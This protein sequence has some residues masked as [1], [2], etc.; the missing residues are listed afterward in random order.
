[1]SIRKFFALACAAGISLG[2][3]AELPVP[4]QDP[5]HPGSLQYSYEFEE[6]VLSCERE[7]RAYLPKGRGRSPVVIY[8]HGQALDHTA[9]RETFIHLARKG[10]AV[11]YPVYDKGFFDQDWQRMG[12][13]YLSLS[14]CALEQLA[15]AVDP[16][17]VV[18]SGHSKGAYVATVAAGLAG[19]EALLPIPGALMTFA[20]AGVDVD[21]VRA[22]PRETLVTVVHAE[23]DGV[24]SRDLAN[25]LFQEAN[26][27]RKQSILAR[28]YPEL[29]AG[30]FWVLTRRTL[31]GGATPGP[32]HY[33]GSWKW[34]VSAA[35][36]LQSSTPT[37]APYL[38]GEAAADKGIPGLTDL[39]ERAGF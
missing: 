19:K 24:V 6:R 9:Y 32:L 27:N 15:T 16:D 10:V 17:A 38:Y 21:L 8:G 26:V 35:L 11:I 39:I 29:S 1:M 2:A 14:Q 31:V 18:F 37:T 13:D 33:Y 22:I 20:A 23:A 4:P 12:R 5:L 7:V 28:S 3:V 30:H 34:L 25:T 36:D